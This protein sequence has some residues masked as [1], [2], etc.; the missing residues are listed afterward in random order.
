LIEKLAF[1]GSGAARIDPLPGGPM[2]RKRKSGC[3]LSRAC[4]I[5]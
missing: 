2:L 5:L 1:E 3:P 4:S